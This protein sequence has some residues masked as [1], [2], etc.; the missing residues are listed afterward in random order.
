MSEILD[1]LS[2]IVGWI[3]FFAWSISF[4]PQFWTN[5]HLGNITGYSLNFG[6]LNL[7]GFLAYFL[8]SLWGYLDTSIF[9]GTVDIQDIAF[10]AH[11]FFITFCLLVQCYS[12]DPDMFKHIDTFVY[13]FLALAWLISIII[14]PIELA[15]DMPHAGNNFNGC[16]WLGY[17]KV[18]ITLMKYFPQAYKNFERKSTEGW[19]IV[20]V[21]LDFTGGVFS[22]LQIFIDGANS[23]DW[24]VFGDGG[25]FNIAKFCL[26]FTSIVFDIVFMIQHYVLYRSRKPS[27]KQLELL[28]N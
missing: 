16:L 25:S 8:Y 12:Y 22:I 26:G 14:C 11:A 7:S 24:N 17:F 2:Q 10:S 4:Y 6:F 20:N 13:I 3:Y 15:G 9:P 19:N 28:D 18:T 23:G 1:I 5:Y 21:I 27:S